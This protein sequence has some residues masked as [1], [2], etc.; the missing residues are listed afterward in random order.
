M[1]AGLAFEGELGRAIQAIAEALERWP[2][3]THGTRRFVMRRFPFV[4]VYVVYVVHVVD[5]YLSPS[6]P[7]RTRDDAPS[8]GK[9]GGDLRGFQ[10]CRA[11]GHC[12]NTPALSTMSAVKSEVGPSASVPCATPPLPYDR[13]V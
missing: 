5:D 3:A 10:S 13:T 9:L 4:V 2:R 1:S 7:W 12:V 6:L 8:T 11:S